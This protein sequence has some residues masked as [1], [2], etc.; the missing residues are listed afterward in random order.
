MSVPPPIWKQESS[1][2]PTPS[3]ALPSR[4]NM[5]P[6]PQGGGGPPNNHQL[7]SLCC[8][9][10]WRRCVSRWAYNVLLLI[11]TPETRR[12]RGVS[13]ACAHQPAM[14]T[15][16][17]REPSGVDSAR[18]RITRND[19]NCKKKIKKGG[20]DEP[21]HRRKDAKRHKACVHTSPQA[22]AQ[23]MPPRRVSVER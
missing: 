20:K 10:P 21:Q 2:R 6:P 15:P 16:H 7:L 1:P 22:D 9:L 3:P 11:D 19:E 18:R 17:V 4:K 13:N 8:G 14:G 23:K 5:P 12:G